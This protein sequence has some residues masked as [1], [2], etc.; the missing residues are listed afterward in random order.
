MG[1]EL[2]GS[3]LGVIGYGAIGREVVRVGKALGMR[4]LVNDP[5]AAGGAGDARYA[6]QGIRLRRAARGGHRRDR[7]SHRQGRA[8]RR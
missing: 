1:R 3:T 7:E 8:S 2:K 5:Y 4:V 6:A